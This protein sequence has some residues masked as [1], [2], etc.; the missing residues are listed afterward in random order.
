MIRSIKAILLFRHESDYSWGGRPAN[1]IGRDR[2]QTTKDSVRGKKF[3]Q[4]RCINWS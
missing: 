2:C 4:M 1:A 3:F